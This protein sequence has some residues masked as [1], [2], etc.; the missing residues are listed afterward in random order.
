MGWSTTVIS[1]PDGD[2]QAYLESLRRCLKRTA[3]QDQIYYP[4]HGAPIADPSSFVAQLIGHRE[5]REAQIKSCLDDGVMNVPEMVV[6]MYAGVP[7]E[8]HPAAQRSVLAHLIHMVETGRA[9][10]NGTPTVGSTFT[11]ID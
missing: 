5:H 9:T 4:T 2:M 7:E 8:L 6:R 10:C 3:S 1:P 11:A